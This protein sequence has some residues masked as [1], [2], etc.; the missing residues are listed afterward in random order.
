MLKSRLPQIAATLDPRV[1]AAMRAGAEAIEQEAKA[2]VTVASGDLR[3]AI[4][5]E[6]DGDDVYVMA[7]DDD[8]FYGHFV[9]FGTTRTPARPFLVPAL[10]ARRESV[11]ASV[12]ATLGRL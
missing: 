3:D 7:G 9:E 4:H 5:T 12:R 10:E 1:T 2:R 8:V 11:L 6:V